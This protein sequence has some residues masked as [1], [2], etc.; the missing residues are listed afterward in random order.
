M[1][2]KVQIKEIGDEFLMRIKINFPKEKPNHLF[3]LGIIGL[4]GSGKTTVVKILNKKLSGTV[5]VK[6]DSARFLLKQA[7]L[8]W[9]DELK[10]LLHY[11]AKN[12]LERGFSVIFDG[13]FVREEKRQDVQ[14]SADELGAKFYLIKIKPDKDLAFARLK[15][16]WE[17]LESGKIKQNFDHFLVVTKGKEKNLFDRV[18]LHENLKSK[19]I[20]QLIGEIE[21][22][23]N[24]EDLEKQLSKIAEKIIY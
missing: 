8:G 9:D 13:D 14:K 12:I 3:V 5:V 17:E 23:G 11:V 19:D 20:P 1:V 7:G 15:E 16:K 21:N 2:D 22:S 24:I 18:P 6:S 10:E 4:I